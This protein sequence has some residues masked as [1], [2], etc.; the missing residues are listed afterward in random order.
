MLSE[1]ARWKRTLRSAGYL[2]HARLKVSLN[3]PQVWSTRLPLGQLKPELRC[4]SSEACGGGKVWNSDPG[5]HRVTEIIRARISVVA[6]RQSGYHEAAMAFKDFPDQKQ[7][8]LLLQRSLERG[9]LAH[10]YLFVGHE[11]E[12]LES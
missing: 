12:Q 8:V 11:L 10:A 6:L 4:R 9:R 3:H 7:G 5:S 1:P 2:Q